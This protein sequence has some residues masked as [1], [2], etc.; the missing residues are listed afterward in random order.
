MIELAW[1]MIEEAQYML[2]GVVAFL[3]TENEEKL[4]LFYKNNRFSQF[5]IRQSD[6]SH[7]LIQLL[8]LL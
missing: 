1:T 3:E 2:G 4:K 8:R 6:E 5:D 7:E